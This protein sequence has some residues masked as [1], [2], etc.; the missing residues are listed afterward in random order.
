MGPKNGEM[1]APRVLGYHAQMPWLATRWIRI[2]NAAMIAVMVGFGAFVAQDWAGLQASL[3]WYPETDA[4]QIWVVALAGLCAVT[5]LCWARAGWQERLLISALWLAATA[6]VLSGLFELIQHIGERKTTGDLMQNYLEG[7]RRVARGLPVY[8]LAGLTQG[9]NA[10]PVA[11]AFFYPLHMLADRDALICFLQFNIAMLGLFTLG[12]ASL[13]RRIKGR[14]SLPDALLPFI[15]LFT[16]NTFQRSWRLG[17]LDTILL[18]I[19]TLGLA[20]APRRRGGGW[21]SAPLLALAAGLKM[22]PVLAA[23]PLLIEGARGM[24]RRLRGKGESGPATRWA[25]IFT[26]TFCLLGALAVARMGPTAAGDFVRNIHRITQSTT[27][28]NNFS[29]VTRAAT[30][31]DRPMRLKH[32][33]LSPGYSLAGSVLAGITVLLL[34]LFSWRLRGADQTLLASVWLTATPFISPVCWDIYWLWCSFLPWLVLWA[35][36][37]GRHLL[38]QA[39]RATR[40]LLWTAL[41]ASYLLAGTFGNTTFTDLKRGVSVHLDLPL[42]MDELPLLGHLLLVGA[43][44][45][46]SVLDHRQAKGAERDDLG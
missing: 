24:L 1:V 14:L 9:V 15:L 18:T 10:S 23:G 44:I 6:L 30:F 13:I 27:S 38:D 43:L 40:M 19:L 3:W 36:I 12:A 46:V 34:G 45:T 25:V 26:L 8:D 28:G 2:A 32:T 37:T 20:L 39:S 17:Q 29:V 4:Y 16:F 22:L 35:H 31:N 42:W 33:T 41:P 7:A 21:Y 5:H 11:I